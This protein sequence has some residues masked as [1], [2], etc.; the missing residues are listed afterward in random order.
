M[1]LLKVQNS[2]FYGAA[3]FLSNIVVLLLKISLFDAGKLQENEM[4]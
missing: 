1:N 4:T 3:V 2:S